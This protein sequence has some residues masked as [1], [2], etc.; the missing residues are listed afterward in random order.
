M[1]VFQ[2]TA[3][4]I[5]PHI[6]QQLSRALHDKHH[7]WR[8]ISIATTGSAG[9]QSR[10]V[11]L[12]DVIKPAGTDTGSLVFFT[13]KRTVKVADLAFDSRAA[14]LC[15]DSRHQVQLRVQ[16]KV[17]W[18]LDEKQ[19]SDYWSRIPSHMHKDYTDPDDV[20]LIHSRS[21]FMVG[22]AKVNGFDWLLLSRSG[23]RRFVINYH[24]TLTVVERNP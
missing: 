19:L 16:T 6:W 10:M 11:V 22:L 2:P 12:R 21:N 4:G 3:E 17:D 23:H 20:E 15:W 7:P 18:L 24:P 1:D 9:P 8:F 13:D 14:I 5:E